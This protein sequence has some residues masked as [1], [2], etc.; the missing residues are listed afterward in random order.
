MESHV[1]WL[2]M[3]PEI[4]RHLDNCTIVTMISFLIKRRT[5]KGPNHVSEG[6]VPQPV[7]AL[8]MQCALIHWHGESSSPTCDIIPDVLGCV[9]SSYVVK[10]PGSD[11]G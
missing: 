3:D 9:S 4:Q 2:A 7:L 1:E 11:A 10:F 8:T 5:H 6:E